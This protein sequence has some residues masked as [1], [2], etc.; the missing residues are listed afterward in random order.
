AAGSA[1]VTG[2]TTSTNFPTTPLAFDTTYGGNE[3]AFVTKFGAGPATHYAVSG[4]PTVTA[5]ATFSITVTALDA[6]N[7]TATAYTGTVHFHQR[8]LAARSARKLPL[9][10]G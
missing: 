7:D 9:H 2:S 8:R 5:G 6:S 10:G 4:P 3:D 1:Y